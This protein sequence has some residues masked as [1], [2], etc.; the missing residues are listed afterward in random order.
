MFLPERMRTEQ[1]VTTRSRPIHDSQTDLAVVIVPQDLDGLIQ[2]RDPLHHTQHGR[3]VVLLL[4][5]RLGGGGRDGRQRRRFRHADL[6]SLAL[7]IH[8]KADSLSRLFRCATRCQ[9]FA[10]FTFVEHVLAALVMAPVAVVVVDSSPFPLVPFRFG[11][12]PC[13]AFPSFFSGLRACTSAGNTAPQQKT[14]QLGLRQPTKPKGRKMNR[15]T[16]TKPHKAKRSETK[17]TSLVTMS[18]T[19]HT[20]T[21]TK[22]QRERSFEIQRERERERNCLHLCVQA[23]QLLISGTVLARNARIRQ[24]GCLACFLIFSFFPVSIRSRP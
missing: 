10:T 9:C 18:F 22:R 6:L 15:S 21:P 12:L 4:L 2:R 11:P 19:Q 16:G 17:Q 1:R 5:G 3:V 14:R 7:F 23:V 8:A 13:F 24:S 20:N